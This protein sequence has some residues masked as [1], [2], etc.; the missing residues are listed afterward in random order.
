M[1]KEKHL[2]YEDQFR[3]AA[4]SPSYDEA[5]RALETAADEGLAHLARAKEAQAS[6][7]EDKDQLIG[8][9]TGGVVVG[10][11]AEIGAAGLTEAAPRWESPEQVEPPEVH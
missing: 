4:T 8:S 10:H 2:T 7:A 11:E 6:R 9:Y 1:S 5:L 3:N